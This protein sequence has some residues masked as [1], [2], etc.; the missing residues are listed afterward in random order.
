MKPKFR[1]PSFVNFGKFLAISGLSLL[2]FYTFFY[3]PPCNKCCDLS[4]PVEIKWSNS[5]KN[6]VDYPTNI[7]HIKFVLIGSLKTWKQ[8]RPY[9]EAWW[10]PNETRGNIFMDSPPSKE[11]L[12][13]PQTVPPFQL[14]EDATKLPVYPK[15]ANPIEARIFRSVLDSF[16]LGDNEDVR[17]FVM[18]DDDTIFF[19]DNLVQVLAKY[20]HTKRYY[21]GMYSEAV[22]SN[23]LFSFDMA[24]GGG[25]YALSYSLVEE[26][27]PLMDDCLERYPFMHT[28]DH[29]SS[30]CLSDLGVGLT[31][32]RGIHQIDLLGDISGMLSSHPQS[33]IVTLHHF[34]NIDPLFPYKNRIESINHLMKAAEVDQPRLVQQTICYHR[35]TNWSVSVSWGYSAHIYE[36]IIPRSVLRKPIETFAPWKNGPPPVYMF[37]TR[38]P[39][40][41]SCQAP[42]VFFM[43]SVR[44]IKGNALVLTTYRRKAPRRLRPCFYTGNHSADRISRIRVFSNATVRMEPGSIKCCSVKYMGGMN[45][46]NIK[47]R[48]CRKGEVIA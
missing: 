23:F 34:D 43:E 1:N 41:D 9:I 25:G 20:D 13:W 36:N 12:P 6:T 26:L 5:S 21:V 28:S 46:V 47:L 11:F 29:L 45:V 16:R 17:W 8:R 18:A 10:R 30:S 32:E 33:P 14:N 42:H 31:V 4:S 2:F 27:A 19:V 38:L 22:I 35:P 24:Y 7:S 48:D 39:T 44:K 37:N 15:L 40:N 3:N